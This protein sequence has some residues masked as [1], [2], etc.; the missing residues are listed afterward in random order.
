ML[1]GMLQV[2]GDDEWW[3][4]VRKLVVGDKDS[5]PQNVGASNGCTSNNWNR[6]TF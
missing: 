2:D 3:R 4:K 6:K 1:A 5:T